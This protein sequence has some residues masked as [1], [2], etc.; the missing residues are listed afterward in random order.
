M[1][2]IQYND[3]DATKALVSVLADSRW[4]AVALARGIEALKSGASIVEA[5]RIAYD[6][7]VPT[8]RRSKELLL[9]AQGKG[10]AEILTPRSRVGSAENPVTKLF[11]A[12]ITE[13]RFLD[14][15]EDLSQRFHLTIQD[16]RQS[17]HSLVDFSLTNGRNALPI[18]V[19]NAGTTFRQ[20]LAVP[21]L[22]K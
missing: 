13:E 10:F 7:G 22:T 18:N 14:L 20:A 3:D 12:T 17:G 16:H 5:S 9:D 15:L 4:E 1:A 8:L 11:P 19:K 6:N 21:V 2:Q